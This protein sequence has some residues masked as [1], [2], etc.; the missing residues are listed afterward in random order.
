[1]YFSRVRVKPNISELSNF[2]NLLRGNG[3]GTHQ[4]L[5]DLFPES[6]NRIL[7]REEI[8]GE[9]IPY[10]KG[11]RGEPIYYVVSKDKP[12]KETPLLSAESKTYEPMLSMGDKLSFK[13]RAN[14]VVARRESENAKSARHDVV[15]NTQQS[16]LYELAEYADVNDFGKKSDLK[17]KIIAGW[18]VSKNLKITEKLRKTIENNER[19]QEFLDKRL[20]DEKLFDIALKAAADSALETWLKRKGIANGFKVIYDKKRGHLRFQA[21]GYRWHALPQKGRTAGFSSVDFE[22]LI[23]VADP[24]IFINALYKGIG[25]AKGFGCGLMLIRRV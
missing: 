18:V 10:H 23:E 14:P 5:F 25:P 7:F 3:Y 22:G 9:Q 15:M 16:L 8:A 2:H 21:E 11:A 20:P 17:R 13:L 6:Q 24:E 12:I 4:I 1:M 19:Y